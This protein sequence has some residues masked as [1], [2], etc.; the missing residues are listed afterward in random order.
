MHSINCKTDAIL[1]QKEPL[2]GLDLPYGVPG[3]FS[4][5]FYLKI[6]FISKFKHVDI[7]RIHVPHQENTGENETIGLEDN[8]APTGARKDERSGRNIFF[9]RF[10]TS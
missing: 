1:W 3:L 2:Q 4:S 5:L 6:S 9:Y 10:Y 7:F 8:L